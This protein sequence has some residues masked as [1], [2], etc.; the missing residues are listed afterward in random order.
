MYY[1][2]SSYL[3][4]PYGQPYPAAPSA[5]LHPAGLRAFPPVDTKIF[6]ASVGSFSKLMSDGSLLLKKLSDHG[7]AHQLMSASQEGKQET[8]DTML[9]GVGSDTP[10]HTSYTPTGVTFT[11]EADDCSLRM[12][13]R[14]GI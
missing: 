11:L 7:F 6:E 2:H 9:K 10:I 8:V 5:A 3:Y 13:L 14:W 1:Y 4:H 12:T